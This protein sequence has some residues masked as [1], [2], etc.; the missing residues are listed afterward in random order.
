MLL[1]STSSDTQVI[2]ITRLHDTYLLTMEHIGTFGFQ[3]LKMHEGGVEG[4][5]KQYR[6]HCAAPKHAHFKPKP[7][8]ELSVLPRRV[9]HSISTSIHSSDLAHDTIRVKTGLVG[10][11]LTHRHLQDGS[12]RPRNPSCSCKHPE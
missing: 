3:G 7:R 8:S 10:V 6:R 11:S 2:G 12:M 4:N 9:S 5:I 1:M